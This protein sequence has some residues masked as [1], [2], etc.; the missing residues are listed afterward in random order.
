MDIKIEKET[1]GLRLQ[2]LEFQ[3]LDKL[4][5]WGYCHCDLPGNWS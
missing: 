1:K 4:H 5:L 3:I 2:N